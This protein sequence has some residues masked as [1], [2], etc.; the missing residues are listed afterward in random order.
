MT[1]GIIFKKDEKMCWKAFFEM[2]RNLHKKK[3]SFNTTSPESMSLAILV[4]QK[5]SFFHNQHFDQIKLSKFCF[6][7]LQNEKKIFSLK[8]VKFSKNVLFWERLFQISHCLPSFVWNLLDNLVIIDR[9]TPGAD[10]GIF[11]RFFFS[12]LFRRIWKKI[13][14]KFVVSWAQ[15]A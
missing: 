14:T 15:L 2:A 9:R 12:L 13:K 1:T 5:S 11:L 4:I 8:I 6:G 3:F 10:K 7:F